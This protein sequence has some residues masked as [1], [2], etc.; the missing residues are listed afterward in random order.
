MRKIN[1]FTIAV[2]ALI[3]CG[4][5]ASVIARNSRDA[6]LLDE[7]HSCQQLQDWKISIAYSLGQQGDEMAICNDMEENGK[8]YAEDMLSA[9]VILLVHP[10]D[11]IAQYG[12]AFMQEAQ[13]LQVIKTPEAAKSPENGELIRIFRPYDGFSGGN[14]RLKFNSTKNIMYSE[15]TYY[16]FLQPMSLNE[17]SGRNE[18][19]VCSPIY[20]SYL[21]AEEKNHEGTLMTDNF[22]EN[23]DKDVF[24][25]TEKVYD[26]YD[27][28][29]QMLMSKLNNNAFD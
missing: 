29:V 3:V 26:A 17:Y 19:T 4:L 14:N 2:F 5:A 10:T 21:K 8:S 7:L 9:P 1:A 15:N 16:V 27:K 18:Y 24:C 25:A 28:V 12:E 6:S 23:H 13:V 11:T 22:N 20:F